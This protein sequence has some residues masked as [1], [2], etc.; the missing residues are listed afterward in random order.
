MWEAAQPLLRNAAGCR[1]AGH[2]DDATSMSLYVLVPH[3]ALDAVLAAPG[4]KPDPPPSDA[5]LAA[6]L[7]PFL[8]KA[9]E[10]LSPQRVN[11][12]GR[13]LSGTARR[14]IATA[15]TSITRLTEQRGMALAERVVRIQKVLGELEAQHAEAKELADEHLRSCGI[16][17]D[18][19]EEYDAIY[20]LRGAEVQLEDA[21][22]AAKKW[23][24]EKEG[25]TAPPRTQLL[26]LLRAARDAGE[27][28]LVYHNVC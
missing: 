6:R 7:Q 18:P 20:S 24:E 27:D 28:V 5:E 11:S 1:R 8:R 13:R 15:R 16:Y 10:A 23:T 25:R 19:G 14:A 4:A 21:L 17:D 9:L 2:A 22:F 26:E 12:G 3:A